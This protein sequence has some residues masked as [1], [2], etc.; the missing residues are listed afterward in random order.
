M[1]ALVVFLMT[2]EVYCAD[3]GP[4]VEPVAPDRRAVVSASADPLCGTR[5]HPGHQTSVATLY[6]LGARTGCSPLDPCQPSGYGRP[7]FNHDQTRLPCPSRRCVSVGQASV[8]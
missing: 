8:T 1:P 4:M 5:P 6:A 2:C 3:S 7:Q